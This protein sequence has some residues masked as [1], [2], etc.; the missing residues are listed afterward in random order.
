MRQASRRMLG[1]GGH[2]PV[3]LFVGQLILEKNLPLVMETLGALRDMNLTACFVGEGYASKELQLL[4]GRLGIA[5]KVHFTGTIRDRQLLK[6]YYAAADLFLFP[7]LYDNAPL[8]VREAAALGLPSLLVEGST[9]AEIISDGVNGFLARNSA[10]AMAARVRQVMADR[11]LRKAVGRMASKTI[12]QPWE[13]I[14]DAVRQR[15]VGIME[16]KSRELTR[17]Q[18][19]I[20]W[21]ERIWPE[22]VL[23]ANIF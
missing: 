12:V 21:P 14:I 9:A 6:H 16:R 2:E 18:H 10:E 5:D 11:H 15:Y 20:P 22:P 13:D 19:H 7:S 17:R 4:A 23:D 1:C 8:V 3:F